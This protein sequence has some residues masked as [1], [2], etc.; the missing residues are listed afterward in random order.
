VATIKNN[1][2][3]NKISF[4]GPKHAF[5]VLAS[6]TVQALPM[7]K[8]SRMKLAAPLGLAL[9]P[10]LA[11]FAP[12]ANAAFDLTGIGYVQYGDAQSYSL[13]VACIQVGQAYNGCDFNVGSTPG[14][15][16]ELVVLATGSNGGPVNE[17]FPG[18]DNAYSMPTGKNGS[19]FMQTGGLDFPVNGKVEYP[20][21]D[22]GQ[23]STFAGDQSNTW[24]A[25]VGALNTFLQGDSMVFFFNN[26]QINSGGT[27]QQ[28]LAAWAQITVTEADG[29]II[30]TFDFTNNNG[31]YALVS[32]GGGGT[33]NGNVTLYTSDR[34]GPDGGTNLN[35]DYV[36]SGGALCVATGAGKQPVPVP[37]GGGVPPELALNGYTAVE[38][39]I[40]HNLGADHAAYA[41]V[42]PELNALIADLISQGKLD[43]VMHV[44]FRFGCDPLLFG[45]DDEADIC[46]GADNG[47]GKNLNNGYEQLFLARVTDVPGPP[48]VASP[49][50]L[51]LM[52][53][54]L[55]A[56]GTLA[57]RRF[58]QAGG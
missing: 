36:L 6:M 2:L 21:A 46:T 58:A 43:A 40:N 31:K 24:D 38:G 28:S 37:C 10:L 48:P 32:E 51:G 41:I 25:T 45:A 23:V 3:K 53:G 27:A 30:G 11:G 5:P 56:L 12:A 55:L 34:T 13:P 50:S 15:I 4:I 29:S 16:K 26:N 44:D 35:T 57:R 17:N 18:M 9:A 47:F 19:N 1:Y 14:Q 54:G 7:N 8:N 22:P 52:A 39:P 33:F 42:F 20:A 49:G